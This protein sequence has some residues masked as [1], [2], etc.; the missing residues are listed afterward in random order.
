MLLDRH[1]LGKIAWHVRIF[2]SDNGQM[3]RQE[4][5]GD[6]IHDCLGG[7][8]IRDLEPDIEGLGILRRDADREG[9]AGFELDR[10]AQGVRF[11]FVIPEERDAGRALLDE[12]NWAVLQLAAG[13]AFGMDVTHLLDLDRTF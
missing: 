4:L 9:T 7:A 8:G 11:H 5:D 3:I 13:E 2:S 10:I 1:G 6:D 12:G